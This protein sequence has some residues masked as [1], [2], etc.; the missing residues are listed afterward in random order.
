MSC[1]KGQ[2]KRASYKRKSYKKKDS[3]IV[4]ATRVPATCIIDRGKP[5]KGEQLFEVTKP[6]LL[7]SYGYSTD[8][9]F[10]DR[11]IS[12]KRAMVKEDPLE[13]LRHLNAIRTLQK[14]NPD[15]YDKMDKDMKYVQ[16][17]YKRMTRKGSKKGSKKVSKK[18]SKKSNKTSKVKK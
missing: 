16:V 8:E 10:D 15:I 17:E 18:G 2:I 3:T 13:V 12:L 9:S 1:P 7:R 14:A 11:K 4:K 5:G 6:Q